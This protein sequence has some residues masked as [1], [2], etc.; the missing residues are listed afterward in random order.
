LALEAGLAVFPINGYF[1][2]IAADKLHATLLVGRI[3][4]DLTAGM[5]EVGLYTDD[6]TSAGIGNAESKLGFSSE[7]ISYNF[8]QWLVFFPF[9]ISALQCANI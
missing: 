3:L 6:G 2:P 8:L 4:I 1:L 5:I 7:V 9:A